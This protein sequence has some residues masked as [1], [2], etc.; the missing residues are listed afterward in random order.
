MGLGY[1]KNT[2]PGAGM[3]GK[4]EEESWSADNLTQL[5]FRFIFADHSTYLSKSK[6]LILKSK[7]YF[8][9]SLHSLLAT[10]DEKY[11]KQEA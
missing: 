4:N 11:F 7:Q 1:M 5:G 9:G 8:S 3:W 2:P 6:F 10:A